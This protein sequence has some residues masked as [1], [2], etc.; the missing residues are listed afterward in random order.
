MNRKFQYSHLKVFAMEKI[1][2]IKTLSAPALL[3][4]FFMSVSI[5]CKKD[6]LADIAPKTSA[7]VQVTTPTQT[8]TPTNQVSYHVSP[9]GNDN[10]NGSL[11]HPFATITK[12]WTVV[13]PGNIILVHGGTYV[14]NAINGDAYIKLINKSGA[15]NKYITISNYA[16]EKPVFDASSCSATNYRAI[17][18]ISN[19][20]YLYIKGIRFTGLKQANTGQGGNYGFVGTAVSNCKFEQIEADH[21]GGYPFFLT[22]NCINDTILNCDAHHGSDPFSPVAYGGSNG[23]SVDVVPITSKGI[24]FIGCRAWM[25]SDDGF[26]GYKNDGYISF[27]NC[28]SFWNGY[29]PEEGIPSAFVKA[30]DGDGF[31]LGNSTGAYDATIHRTCQNCLSIENKLFGFDQNGLNQAF[32]V[33]NCTSYANLLGPIHTQSN[34]YVNIFRNNLSYG[35]SGQTIGAAATNDHNSWNLSISLTASD[36]LSL[37]KSQL[38]SPRNADGSLPSITLLHLSGSSQCQNKGVNV[39]LPYSG[40]APNLGC[41]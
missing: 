18:S 13:E 4:A 7:T 38:V 32:E 10:N 23:F 37:D 25:N 24:V 41:F 26:E 40:I 15:S 11:E 30:G 22:G 6:S 33:I 20:N 17:I 9:Q 36:F 39:G 5:S 16:G 29:V 27:V 21:I 28:W 34:G 8:T 14:I 2:S 1:R 3:L 19:C 35:E 12:A 31:K